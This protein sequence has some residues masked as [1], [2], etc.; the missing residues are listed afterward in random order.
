MSSPGTV[1]KAR[2]LTLSNE[3]GRLFPETQIVPAIHR[4]EIGQNRNV[5]LRYQVEAAGARVQGARFL[6]EAQTVGA[7]GDDHERCAGYQGR[8]EQTPARI[9]RR[10]GR[11]H[12]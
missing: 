11:G 5:R 8:T 9:E 12:S 6:A 10:V 7:D 3:R 1:R 2:D 4:G